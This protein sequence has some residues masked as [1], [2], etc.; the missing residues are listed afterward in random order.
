[1]CIIVSYLYFTVSGVG[2]ILDLD[3]LQDRFRNPSRAMETG[4]WEFNSARRRH[5]QMSFGNSIMRGAGLL[6]ISGD[7]PRCSCEA[8][9]RQL[10]LAPAASS[11]DRLVAF[12]YL[13]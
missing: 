4:F 13:A 12:R 5:G 11:A 8:T 9:L 10:T 7:F 3:A 6:R 1:M 2:L